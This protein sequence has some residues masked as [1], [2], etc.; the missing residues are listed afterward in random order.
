MPFGLLGRA[1]LVFP[2]LLHPRKN[3]FFDNGWL[4][5]GKNPLVLQGIMQP[6]FQLVGFGIGLEIHCAAGVL[7]PLQ[8]SRHR[9]RTPLIRLLGQRLSVP[10]GIVSFN[11]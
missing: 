6:L 7:W 8:D 1:A 3:L 10:L 11:R 9:F 4:G 5:I 2:Q